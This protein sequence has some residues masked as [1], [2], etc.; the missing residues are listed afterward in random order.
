MPPQVRTA[1]AGTPVH[2]HP[3]SVEQS[4]TAE[5]DKNAAQKQEPPKQ[6]TQT[7]AKNA[8]AAK[9]LAGAKKQQNV[10]DEQMVRNNLNQKVPDKK[11]DK[12]ATTVKPERQKPTAN[13]SGAWSFVKEAASI[14]SKAAATGVEIIR[15]TTAN[16]AVTQGVAKLHQ[17]E[18]RQDMVKGEYFEVEK[19]TPGATDKTKTTERVEDRS[20]GDVAARKYHQE[21]HRT[22]TQSGLEDRLNQLN[23][24]KELTPF[25]KGLVSKWNPQ[26]KEGD[27][28]ALTPIMRVDSTGTKGSTEVQA[29]KVERG[30]ETT[31]YDRNGNT[32]E[33]ESR[34]Q[35]VEKLAQKKYPQDMVRGELF[36]V[37]NITPGNTNKTKNRE[38]ADDLG[39]KD[40]YTGNLHP[41][42]HRTSD[43]TGLETRL[44]ELNQGKELTAFEKGVISEWDPQK[45]SGAEGKDPITSVSPIM[46]SESS[47]RKGSAEVEGY[48]VE[49]GVSGNLQTTYYDRHG[50]ELLAK[51]SGGEA[52]P[53]DSPIDY[54]TDAKILKD[55]VVGA[56]EKIAERFAKETTSITTKV[57]KGA[58][59]NS[60]EQ[61][62][63]KG[64]AGAGA[65]SVDPH[66]S[67]QRPQTG[68]VAKAEARAGAR[69]ADPAPAASPQAETVN[70]GASVGSDIGKGAKNRPAETAPNGF[71]GKAT[72]GSAKVP[73]KNPPPETIPNGLAGRT[74]AK[75]PTF[76]AYGNGPRPDPN[77]KFRLKT[78]KGSEEMKFS[79]Y[80]RRYREAKEWVQNNKSWPRDF[81]QTLKLQEKAAEKFGLQ[82]TWYYDANDPMHWT[83]K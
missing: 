61:K 26:K 49:R 17:K 42:H 80:S 52:I 13:Q 30:V 82:K 44:K 39:L 7:T 18:Y 71:A 77:I 28:T 74:G 76:V 3:V 81:E 9:Q 67:T 10:A 47:G 78:V 34:Q 35:K 6:D 38:H 63:A 66:A 83:M 21:Q 59:V 16:A 32:I 75:D 36:E 4:K 19:I 31:Y 33:P 62:V 24:G 46:G 68:D 22:S 11:T 50:N 27:I 70:T 57:E 15:N 29:Y 55:V 41:S 56:G 40:M 53:T 12:P 37:E 2:S 72:P 5:F 65:R 58:I 54:A 48:K 8:E 20:R 1:D 23:Q 43:Q 51:R 14:G 60:V 79:E 69:P 73:P 25:E 64:E 45:K